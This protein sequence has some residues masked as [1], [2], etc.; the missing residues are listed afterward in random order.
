MEI[1]AASSI[2]ESTYMRNPDDFIAW[3][4]RH[5]RLN[6]SV[7]GASR[8]AVALT[9]ATGLAGAHGFG[10]EGWKLAHSVT[11]PASRPDA[12]AEARRSMQTRAGTGYPVFYNNDHSLHRK[13]FG[14]LLMYEMSAEDT[15]KV[16]QGVRSDI[17]QFMAAAAHVDA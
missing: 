5:Q 2:K 1:N 14:S 11:L 7:F 10:T 15:A 12:T 6:I 4:V 13:V 9:K 17:R 3:V 16:M 8:R